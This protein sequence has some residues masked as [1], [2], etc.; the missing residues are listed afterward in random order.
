VAHDFHLLADWNPVGHISLVTHD[1]AQRIHPKITER[2]APMKTLTTTCLAMSLCLLA[3]PAFADTTYRCTYGQQE[4]I[5]SV[6]YQDQET[7]VPCEVLYQK[8]GVTATLWSAQ[9]EVGYCEENAER[10]VEK[11][12]RWGWLCKETDEAVRE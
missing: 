10:F 3:S 5:I 8:D 12:R 9:N 4:R 11:Q 7:K 2:I 1:N 6:V